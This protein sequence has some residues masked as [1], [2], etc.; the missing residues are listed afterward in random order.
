[1]MQTSVQRK[2]REIL[3]T[4][5][6]FFKTFRVKR[7]ELVPSLFVLAMFVALNVLIIQHYFPIFSLTGKA[8]WALFVNNFHVSGFDPITYTVLSKWDAAYNI[9]R[10]PLLAFFVYPLYLLNIW[11]TD[12]LGF[13][14]VQIVVLV[15][16]LF[17]SYY[18]FIFMYRIMREIIGLKRIDSTLLAFMLFSFAYV[19]L[20]FMVPDHFGPSM[21]ML[22]LCLY[23]CAKC[24]QKGRKLKIW[25]TW[26]LFIFTAGT[27]LSN[28]IKIFLDALFVNRL[29]FFRPKYFLLAVIIPSALIWRLAVWEYKTFAWPREVAAKVKQK[30]KAAKDRDKMLAHFRDTTT[31]TDSAKAMKL[32]KYQL[33]QHRHKV[34]VERHKSAGF[35]HKGTPMGKG[36]FSSWTD[37]STP[38]WDSAVENLFGESIILH[39]DYLLGDTLRNRPVLVYYNNVFIYSV[40]AIIVLLLIAGICSGWRSRFLQMCL[41]GVA[42]DMF[43]H[44]VLGFGLNEVYIMAPHWIF[45]IPIA[46][47]FL[48]SRLC[49]WKLIAARSLCACIVA[50]LMV[51]NISLMVSYFT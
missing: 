21:F 16:L 8:I 22:V 48:F 2:M 13:N 17:F 28:G 25:Q 27:T 5:K 40:E 47:G 46:I 34:Y 51:Y 20:A 26:L 45:I 41:A 23:V 49:G 3:D 11:L 12:L 15:P 42:F 32:F 4:L 30:Q 44:V 24:L 18:T 9:Y 1:M 19:A 6:K 31:I 7:E 29:S 43:I 39:K 14:P 35:A 50:W 36:E 10:H 37:K 33:Q 38:R